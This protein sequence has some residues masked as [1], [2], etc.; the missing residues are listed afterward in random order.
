M[1]QELQTSRAF[2]VWNI[3]VRSASLGKKITYKSLGTQAYMHH[4]VLRFPLEQI[5]RFCKENGLPPLTS[6]VVRATSGV[7]GK[8]NAVPLGELE[9]QFQKIVEFEWAELENPFHATS[10]EDPKYWWSKKS[11]EKYWVESTDRKDLG[12]NVISRN[13]GSNAYRKLVS[14]VKSGDIVFHYYQPEKAII[15]YSVAIGLPMQSVLKW[16]DRL[17]GQP[18]P[19]TE[20]RLTDYTELAE[21][22]NLTALQ[23]KDSSLRAI[24]KQ[25]RNSH[26]GPLYLPFQ[27]PN[28]AKFGPAQG[29]YLSKFP[30]EMVDIFEQLSAAKLL[31]HSSD[32]VI[33]G[34]RP[35]HKKLSSKETIKK[36]PETVFG[37][38]TDEKKKK[39]TELYGMSKA[40]K[41]LIE[42]GFEVRD[43]S[44][45][46][47]RGFDLLA[48]LGERVIGV[49]VKASLSSR[50]HVD[51]T[52]SE[53]DFAQ[54]AGVE[55]MLYL[56]DEIKL[57][58][59][60]DSYEAYDG[61]ERCWSHWRPEDLSLV[62]TSF[63]YTLPVGL[64]D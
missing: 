38:Q 37:R 26:K 45:E 60:G 29:A 32:S 33:S 10:E 61:R 27:F 64:S 9:T 59:T 16:P 51:L 40:T 63:R 13:E 30:K 39:A 2:L 7:P 35:I 15:A 4:R 41:Y 58:K 23:G 53:V 49:E 31:A 20:V 5:Q 28:S 24:L 42:R 48:T 3:L 6:I 1:N 22:L 17:N 62:P 55:S 14:A 21:P 46:K 19:A 52:A 34:F 25:L 8:G 54:R 11:D 44:N 57:R 36:T 56:V 12:V 18:N 50:T 43:V 47:F